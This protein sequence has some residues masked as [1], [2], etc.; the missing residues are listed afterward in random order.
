MSEAN[1]R[2][3]SEEE[4]AMAAHLAQLVERQIEMGVPAEITLGV[5]AGA[6]GGVAAQQ[7]IGREELP[8]LHNWVEQAYDGAIEGL[9]AA[10]NDEASR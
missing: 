3:F 1:T 4:R 2:V 10:A 8:T 5:L 6:L 9:K 7:G